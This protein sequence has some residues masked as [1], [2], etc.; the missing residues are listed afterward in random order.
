MFSAGAA[1]LGAVGR[2]LWVLTAV[3]AVDNIR[4]AGGGW[5]DSAE[6][7]SILFPQNLRQGSLS[8]IAQETIKGVGVCLKRSAKAHS[9]PRCRWVIL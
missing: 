4:T 6:Q 1:R 9:H 8:R 5:T 3:I 7:Q 2:G